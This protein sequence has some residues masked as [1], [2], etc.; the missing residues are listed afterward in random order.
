MEN[1]PQD[2]EGLPATQADEEDNLTVEKIAEIVGGLPEKEQI[3]LFTRIELD[4]Y[5]HHR[6]P[7]PMASEAERWEKILPGAAKEFI[8]FAKREQEIRRDSNERYAKYKTN[9]LNWIGFLALVML[10]I[11]AYA[12]HLGFPLIAVPIGMSGI[13]ALIV[14]YVMEKK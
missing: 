14:R 1:D 13:I 7:V 3:K 4:V 6:G 2:G 12:T 5:S 11:T 8:D 9:Q 10:G